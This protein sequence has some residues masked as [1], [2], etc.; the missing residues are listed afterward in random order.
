MTLGGVMFLLVVAGLLVA[1]VAGYNKLVGL[2]QRSQEAWSDIDVQLKR[3]TD[4]V[5][6][7]VETVKG[8]AAHEKTT[9]DAVTRA[10]G[11]AVAAQTPEARAQAENALTGALRQLFAL[12][13]AYPNLKANENFTQLQGSLSEIEEAIQNSRRYYNAVVR[14]FNTT[15]DSVPTNVLASFFRFAKRS[16]FEL[17][18]RQDRQAP[19]VAFGS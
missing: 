8:Y 6:N 7:L 4:L 1:I 15:I 16:Y 12:A 18:S 3:R 5:P 17:D 10:R 19:R 11:A 9:L 14:D 13:E 2:R